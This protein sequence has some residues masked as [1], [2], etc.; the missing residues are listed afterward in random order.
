MY[1]LSL[2]N[3]KMHTNIYRMYLNRFYG[4][5]KQIVIAVLMYSDV[6]KRNPCDRKENNPL[7]DT[8]VNTNAR[9]ET[10]YSERLLG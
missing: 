5:G 2:I 7:S 9:P 6:Y 8:L 1:G 10:R 3:V 4:V